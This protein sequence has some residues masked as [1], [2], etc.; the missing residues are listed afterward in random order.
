MHE[1]RRRLSVLMRGAAEE[2]LGQ[3]QA[4]SGAC[5][6]AKILYLLYQCLCTLPAS[7]GEQKVNAGVRWR[8]SPTSGFGLTQAT[9]KNPC[10]VFYH[11]KTS[12]RFFGNSTSIALRSLSA[13]R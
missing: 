7:P 4:G 12:S 11:T 2:S 1:D 10:K 9:R 3:D 5:R 8:F 6:L 13:H